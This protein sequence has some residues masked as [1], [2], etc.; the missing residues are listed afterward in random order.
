MHGHLDVPEPAIGGEAYIL[1][2]RTYGYFGLT[3]AILRLPLVIFDVLFGHTAKL[4][5]LV[6]DLLAMAGAYGVLREAFRYRGEKPDGWATALIVLNVG[7][8]STVFFFSSRA[9]IYHEAILC[10]VAF[11]LLSLWFS[12]RHLARPEGRWWV[13]ALICATLSAHARPPVGL[14]A[15]TFVAG[16]ALTHRRLGVTFMAVMALASVNAVSFL[17]FGNFEGMPLHL[18]VQA[19][20][21]RLAQVEGRIFHLSNIPYT[22]LTYFAE[23]NLTTSPDFPFLMLNKPKLRQIHQQWPDTRLMGIEPT[24]SIP[25]AMPGLF[26]LAVIGSLAGRRQR[27]IRLLWLSGIPLIL[28]ILS[29]VSISQRYTGDLCPL[30]IALSGFGLA[31]LQPLPSW[32]LARNILAGT[33]GI[34]MVMTSVLIALD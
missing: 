9:V 20:A 7:L 30:F 18:Y 27:P 2:G 15:L 17:K 28:I 1:E 10:G 16:V 26:I 6:Y 32:P 23:P 34:A 21:S 25:Y 29:F 11:A 31:T 19:D 12:L 5:M 4:F 8:G 13:F 3:P 24:L 33:T 22:I 14:F